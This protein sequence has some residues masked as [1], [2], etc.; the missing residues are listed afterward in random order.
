[1][2][3]PVEVVLLRMG[4][5]LE[6]LL[7]GLNIH[8]VAVRSHDSQCDAAG[9]ERN[10]EVKSGV[11][12]YCIERGARQESQ[13]KSGRCMAAAERMMRGRECAGGKW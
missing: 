9:K 5:S 11:L 3:K 1:M 10:E 7:S 4:H 8:L 2:N 12:G 6:L 13:P